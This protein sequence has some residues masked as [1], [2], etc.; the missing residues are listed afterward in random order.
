MQQEQLLKR[1]IL[2]I[3]SKDFLAVI[4]AVI[5]PSRTLYIGSLYTSGNKMLSINEVTHHNKS[6]L[7]YRYGTSLQH[8]ETYTSYSHMLE[9]GG[10][11]IQ[12]K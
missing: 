12:M 4:L 3:P 6:L 10:N 11:Y 1:L 9:H 5:S 8:T 7:V 2:T